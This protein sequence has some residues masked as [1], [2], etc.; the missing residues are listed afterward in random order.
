MGLSDY[1]VV[2]FFAHCKTALMQIA[3]TRIDAQTIEF[4]TPL[5]TED[6][7]HLLIS[8]AHER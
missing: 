2:I 4:G 6:C 8:F 5:S 3:A 7:Q 1:G